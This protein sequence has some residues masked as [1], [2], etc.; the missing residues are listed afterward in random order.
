M[1]MAMGLAATLCLAIGIWP[2]PLY[3]LLPYP[4]SY[5][6][7]TT[8]HVLTQLQLIAF[9]GLA[10]A[11]LIRF[12]LNPVDLRSINLDVD[13]LY[14]RLLPGLIALI[15]QQMRYTWHGFTRA[16]LYRLNR[17]LVLVR[18]TH[19]PQGVIAR[20]WQTGSMVLWILALLGITLF[21]AYL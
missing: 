15:T 1:L 21:L 19:G 6:P 2:A 7:F 5:D 14:R 11:L 18:R 8:G 10:F 17:G 16:S 12:K 13:W 3:E 20:T 9:A 4:V